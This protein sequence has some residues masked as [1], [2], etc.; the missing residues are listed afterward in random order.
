MSHQIHWAIS[1]LLL[2]YIAGCGGSARKDMESSDHLKALSSAVIFHKQEHGQWPDKLE[3]IKPQLS[4]E[5]VWLG[6]A[7]MKERDFA[8]LMKNPITNANPGYEYVK[9]PEK[10]STAVAMIYQLRDGKRD[11]TL[12]VATAAGAVLSLDELKKRQAELGE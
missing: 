11:E 10:G 8:S 7:I 1:M 12:K 2:V 4:K 5:D 6:V 3:D 9:P